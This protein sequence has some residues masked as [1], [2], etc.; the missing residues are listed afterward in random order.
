MFAPHI[1]P[2]YYA[3]ASTIKK[4]GAEFALA[5]WNVQKQTLHHN[6]NSFIQTLDHHHP[7][8]FLLLQEA[9]V[10][11]HQD[12]SL[13]GY[14]YVTAPNIQIRRHIYGVMTATHQEFLQSKAL[15]TKARESW[16]TTRKSALITHHPLHNERELLL[17]NVHAIN[18]TSNQAFYKEL[19]R[20]AE[21]VDAH[22]GPMIIA[23]D[24]NTWNRGREKSLCDFCHVLNIEHAEIGKAEYAKKFMRYRLDHI[25][26][27]G[28][29]LIEAYAIDTG[30]FSDHN[31]LYARFS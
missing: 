13:T 5:T 23:G 29:K 12:F 17:A 18:F 14:S 22:Q 4:P 21:I 31:P 2:F 27:R 9:K 24:F 15:L 10:S 19:H 28:L 16:W 6:F 7:T 1:S 20:L 11:Q 8:D 3:G 26:Y 30:N 25:L